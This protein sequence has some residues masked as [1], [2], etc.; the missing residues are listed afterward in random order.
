MT[1]AL[2]DALAKAALDTYTALPARGKPSRRTNGASEW[3]VLA[4]F[5]L[6][7][8]FEEGVETKL[9]VR[10]VSLG[11]GLKALPHV[12][13]PVHGDVLH[14]SH[15]EVIARRGL[16]LWLY[17][18]LA[19]TAQGDHDSLLERS[20]EENGTTEWRLKE[21]WKIGMYVSTLPCGDASTY[22]LALQSSPEPSASF[23]QSVASAPS[24][25]PSILSPINPLSQVTDSEPAC[26]PSLSTALS[27]GLSLS[28]HSTPLFSA[29]DN[30]LPSVIRGRNGYTTLSALRTKPGRADSPPTTA[31]SCSDKIALWSLLGA[32]G[33]LLSAL[34][35]TKVPIEVLVVGSEGVP[36][37]ERDKV[38]E[39]VRR[40]VGG[41]LETWARRS[42]LG[43]EDFQ[44]PVVKWTDRVYEHAREAVAR[45]EGVKK[46][47]V[48][49]CAE[50]LSYVGS[51]S[52]AVEVITNGIRQG[53]ASKRKAGE[54][55]TAKNRSRLS[56]LSLFQLHLDVQARLSTAPAPNSQ[57][58][59]C[60]SA[61]VS[62]TTYYLAK[63]PPLCAS[64]RSDL[65]TL[66]SFTP[67]QCYQRLKALV[68]HRPSAADGTAD[69]AQ[70]RA[71][72]G[73]FSAWLV[74]GE[75]WESFDG[76]G[77]AVE[78]RERAVA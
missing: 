75:K 7:R 43:Q 57:P 61:S 28:R 65:S 51:A 19:R 35:V 76:A 55:L 13:L 62:S 36:G 74:S 63:H 73:P 78:G 10:C 20:T 54:A 16:K 15:A 11:T 46:E 31:H 66:P 69:D 58:L 8:Q 53:A 56:K 27:L 60:S 32:Q 67:G 41:R 4:A 1:T 45:R 14:D 49:G 52:P 5:L 71:E 68:R 25:G 23:S 34:G 29:A 9:D 72:A 48:A 37:E 17:G 21:G 26:H 47:E 2:A 24:A 3:T 40:A 22:L 77:K 18:Q 33:G 6:F 50:S 39:E 64:P 44:V 70:S 30:P 59:P 12:R 42:G 38:R